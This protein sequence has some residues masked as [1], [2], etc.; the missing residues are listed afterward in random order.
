MLKQNNNP[1]AKNWK[2]TITSIGLIAIGATAGVSGNYLAQK[3]EDSLQLA[4]AIAAPLPDAPTRNNFITAV[5]EKVG[6]AVVRI[7]ASRTVKAEVPEAL[8]DPFFQ[9]FFGDRIPRS[10]QRVEEGTGSGFIISSDGKIL[11]NAHVVA[12]ADRVSVVLKDGRTLQGKVMGTD[13]VTDV[14]VI[15]VEANNLPVV[16]LGNSEDLKPGEWAI[17]IGNPLGLDNTVTTGIISGTGRS[18][19]QVGIPDKRVNFIQTDA[20][21]NPGNSG[22]PLL[23]ANGQVIGMNTA[24]IRRAQ[25]LGFAI[26]INLA[27]N[28]SDRLVATGKVDHSYLGIQMAT[29][30][31]EIKRRVNSNP[32][33]RLKIDEDKGVLV[34]RVVPSSPAARSGLKPGDII[35]QVNNQPTTT[36]DRLQQLVNDVQVGTNLPLTLRRQGETVQVNIRTGVFPVG[37]LRN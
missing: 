3:T 30:T 14:A 21:I 19:S 25:G 4:P 20:A 8:R 36:A 28:I 22:G 27:K 6:P 1:K 23:N 35:T 33:A 32:D 2:K 9:E 24:I 13:P 7:D 29:I 16:S 11:T 10:Q 18:S 37:Q 34:L 15:K 12:G 31:P 17:A 26:P 5:V